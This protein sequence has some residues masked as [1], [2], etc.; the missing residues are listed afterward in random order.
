MISHQ[1][2][3][4]KPQQQHDRVYATTWQEVVKSN[5]VVAGTLTIL[6][7]YALVLF[8]SGSSQSFCISFYLILCYLILF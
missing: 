8:D 6:R 1:G 2:S 3:Y 4:S 7:Y 5:T